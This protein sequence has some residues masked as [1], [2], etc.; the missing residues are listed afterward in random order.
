MRPSEPHFR[1]KPS[2][3]AEAVS[4]ASGDAAI[5]RASSAGNGTS[6]CGDDD[7]V[8]RWLRAVTIVGCT[9]LTC[10][11][12]DTGTEKL[13]TRGGDESRAVPTKI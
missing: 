9:T 7:D 5:G 6:A 10:A 8:D 3:A 1:D 12:G 4:A 13:C 11:T 2:D